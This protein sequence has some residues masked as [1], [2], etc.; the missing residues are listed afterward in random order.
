MKPGLDAH[1]NL[2]T[3][4]HRWDPRHKLVALMALIFSFAFVR[5]LRLLPALLAAS[6]ALYLAS[7][8]PLSFLL[9]RLRLPGFFL[10]MIAVILPFLSGRTVLFHIGP[11]AVREEGCLALLLIAVKFACIL[12]VGTVLFGTTP[13]LAAVRAMQALGLPCILAD[14][15]FFSYRYL[16]EIGDDLKTMQTAMRL[17]GFRGRR[18][19]SLSALASLAGTL[20][21][22]SYEQS[23]RVFKAMI[24]RGYGQ[25][26]SFRDEFQAGFRDLAWSSAVLLAAAGLAAA[27]MLLR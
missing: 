10:L 1:A 22:R 12:T 26:A 20:L 17:R 15:T 13:F 14:M 9:G 24:L 8:L 4:L 19:G 11:L 27:E 16:Y 18:P 3:P 2:S 23:D 25:A 7:G 5:D 21:V 6:G